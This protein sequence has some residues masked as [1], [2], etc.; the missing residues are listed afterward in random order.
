MERILKVCSCR[1]E[2][3]PYDLDGVTVVS[4]DPACRVHED[5]S[6]YIGRRVSLEPITED[7]N[8]REKVK[9]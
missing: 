6:K 8:S 7:W 4:R 2:G 5:I 1:N 9:K 3:L